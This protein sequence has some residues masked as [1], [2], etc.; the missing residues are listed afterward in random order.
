M[1]P[2][3]RVEWSEEQRAA[4]SALLARANGRRTSR[5]LNFAEVER[6]AEEALRSELGF[7]WKSAGDA[8]DA[9]SMT[10]VCL[11]VA[12][13]EQ[14]TIGVAPAH[15]AATPASAWSDITT[16]D[17]YR[18]PAN[19]SSCRAWAGRTRP[20]RLGLPLL[21]A[22][23]APNATREDM[24]AAVRAEPEADAP[25]LVFADWLSDR[26]DP[27]GAFIAIQC[28][29]AR[30]SPRAAELE[31]EAAALLDA[32]GRQWLE[33]LSPEV[34]QARF[35]RGFVESAEV[36]DSQALS[37]LE[38]FF[39]TEPVTELV[40]TSSRAIDGERFATLEWVERL[41]SVECRAAR[42]NAPG[43]LSRERLAHVLDSRRLRKL[44][45]LALVG[46]RLGDEGLSL[47]AAQG[48]AAL[49]GLECLIVEDDAITEK[50]V[51]ALAS[52]K[53]ATRFVELSLADN[54]LGVE[55]TEALAESRSPGRLTRLSLGGNQMGNEGAIAIARA[56][57][58]RTLEVLSLPRNRIGG[59]GLDA[60]LESRFLT[61][62]SSLDLSGNPLGSAGKRRLAASLSLRSGERG[63]G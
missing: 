1:K 38:D 48:G 2:G 33:G 14:L 5:L 12:G 11:C 42:P 44:T 26:G 56:A 52:S 40:F 28:E 49:P 23:L 29:L 24:L 9:R 36:R 58:F 27:R 32:H 31:E 19:A 54:E 18:E 45:R 35:R 37:Q 22:A 7:A 63:S 55:G 25:R 41:R 10:S 17:R 34:V 61:Q 39:R 62:L 30:G 3:R 15:G 4:L 46:Q 13:A 50:G 16:W 43:A 53:W 6:C 21:S 60:L 47:L 51:T 8:P 20:D 59:A 57:R